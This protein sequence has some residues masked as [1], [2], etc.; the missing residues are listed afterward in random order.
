M[1]KTF[2]L[3]RIFFLRT[4]IDRLMVLSV[5][6]SISLVIATYIYTGHLLFFFLIWNM[7][8]ACIP[9]GISLWL[10]QRPDW[11]ENRKLFIPAL[12]LWI[13]FIPNTFY[14]LTDLFH[15]GSFPQLPSWFELILILSFAWNGMLLG[16]LSVGHMEKILRLE[17]GDKTTIFFVYPIMFLNAL[18]VYIGRY[19]RFN[20]WDIITNPFQL[21][22]DIVLM[23]IHPLQHHFAW[24]MVGCFSVFMTIVYAMLRKV[25]LKS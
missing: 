9:Y 23:V 10:L 14:I 7:F 1:G 13:A 17:A 20:S 21:F 5:L 15:L 24:G 3:D 22:R 12:L 19:L 2:S 11:I 18:G 4:A 25:E 8:L 6:F 16:I